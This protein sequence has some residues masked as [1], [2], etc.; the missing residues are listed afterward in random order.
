MAE[1]FLRG[2]GATVRVYINNAPK[3]LNIKSWAI[4]ELVVEVEDQVGGELRARYDVV[5]N[6]Y[7]FTFECYEDSSTALIESQLLG[8]A[9][10]DAFNPPINVAGGFRFEYRNGGQA[11]AF[12]LNGLTRPPLDLKSSGR[13]DAAMHSGHLRAQYFNQVNA[14]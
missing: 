10:D 3:V 1:P 11:K 12:T 13:T 9:N 6:G 5:T 14:V 7:D 8:N 2:L 4:K